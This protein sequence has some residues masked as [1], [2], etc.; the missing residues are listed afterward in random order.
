MIKVTDTNYEYLQTLPA[1]ISIENIKS[2][3]TYL[4]PENYVAIYEHECYVPDMDSY[5]SYIGST[6]T[7]IK[8]RCG[9]DFTG[10]TCDANTNAKFAKYLRKYGYIGVKSRLLRVVRS[11]LRAVIEQEEI[12]KHNSIALGFNTYR[13]MRELTNVKK[14]KDFT[15]SA[16][17]RNKPRVLSAE[18]VM[19]TTTHR[20]ST[21]HELVMNA[22]MYKTLFSDIVIR[23]E[24]PGIDASPTCK[25]KGTNTTPLRVLGNIL[26]LNLR[27]G[28]DGKHMITLDNIYVEGTKKSLRS[29]LVENP[30]TLK[31]AP[32]LTLGTWDN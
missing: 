18:N 1:E 2:H 16:N 31:K 15:T 21:N 5:S 9:D 6:D 30:E 13:A 29:Y 4:P 11:D 3:K 8:N 7:S 17:K 24:Y 10:Y 28:P 14:P 23:L 22:G 19:L 12:D 27:Y 20:D 25:I 32:F 26:N